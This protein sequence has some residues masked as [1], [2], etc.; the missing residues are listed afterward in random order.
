MSDMAGNAAR[1]AVECGRRCRDTNQKSYVQHPVQ[2]QGRPVPNQHLGQRRDD[3][4]HEINWQSAVGNPQS[5]SLAPVQLGKNRSRIYDNGEAKLRKQMIQS[6]S[7]AR[8]LYSRQL[9]ERNG[10]PPSRR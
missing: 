9:L 8:M 1:V 5:I 4:G 6:V 7:V 2:K 10:P 3:R